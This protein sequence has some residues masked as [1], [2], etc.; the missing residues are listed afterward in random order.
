MN[1][2]TKKNDSLG[3]M[4]IEII[5]EVEYTKTMIASFIH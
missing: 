5:K 2:T 4:L 3:N 1:K